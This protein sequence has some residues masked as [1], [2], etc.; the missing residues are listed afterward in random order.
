MRSYTNNHTLC[1]ILSIFTIPF[2]SYSENLNYIFKSGT[3]GYNT[4]RIPSIV[5]SSS[6]VVLAFAEGRKNSSS[7]SG[8]IDIVLKRSLDGGNSWGDMV[9][10]RDD[11]LNVCGILLR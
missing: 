10:I 3:D 5:T 8:D 7:D 6:G 1:L 11:G 2:Y 4:F 9:I